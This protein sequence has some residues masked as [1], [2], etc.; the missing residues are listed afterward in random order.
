MTEVLGRHAYSTQPEQTVMQRLAT[1]RGRVKLETL[2][3][4]E[5]TD[6]TCECHLSSAQY[7]MHMW[8]C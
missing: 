1:G 2:I 6:T 7:N 5:T 8:S 4:A 3:A